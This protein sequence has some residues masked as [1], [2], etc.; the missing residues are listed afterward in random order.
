[1]V[2][3]LPVNVRAG[4][5]GHLTVEMAGQIT[6]PATIDYT[7]TDGTAV[8]GTDYLVPPQD[9]LTFQ[10]GQT[11]PDT[12]PVFTTADPNATANKTFTVTLSNPTGDLTI[13]T[14]QAVGTIYEPAVAAQWHSGGSTASQASTG[15]GGAGVAGCNNRRS[16]PHP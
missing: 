15:D 10:P 11:A 1:M 13:G 12:L 14:G 6:A 8:Q 9:T 5:V 16:P 2:D 7:V 4:H 3:V